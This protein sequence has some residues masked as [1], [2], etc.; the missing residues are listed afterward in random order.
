MIRGKK[1]WNDKRLKK[2]ASKKTWSSLDNTN[3]SL[4]IDQLWVLCSTDHNIAS[5]VSVPIFV[6]YH[7]SVLAQQYFNK[8]PS[9]YNADSPYRSNISAAQC[10]QDRKSKFYRAGEKCWLTKQRTSVLAI[11][12]GQMRVPSGTSRLSLIGPVKTLLIE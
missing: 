10:R 11:L 1:R 5:T 2:K 4:P 6:V 3:G 8:G 7:F 9:F 12:A